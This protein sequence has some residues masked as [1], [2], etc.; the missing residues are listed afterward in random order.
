M[1]QI[2][3]NVL[4]RGHQ[5]RN[6]RLAL[7]FISNYLSAKIIDNRTIQ[8]PIW[9]YCHVAAY[10]DRN[11]AMIST[12]SGN[13]QSYGDTDWHN[14]DHIILF[15]DIGDGRCVIYINKIEPLFTHRTI[16]QHGVTWEQISKQSSHKEV[17]KS[18]NV[19]KTLERIETWEQP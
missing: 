19:L 12:P 17:L 3:N 4:E 8:T 6:K 5:S 7:S 1:N 15:R 16:G 14:N 13:D 9:G 18:E 10:T 2:N 11:G